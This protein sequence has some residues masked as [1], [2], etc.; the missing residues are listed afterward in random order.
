MDS[1]NMPGLARD[2]AK[3]ML[4]AKESFFRLFVHGG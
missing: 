2:T 3:N 4:D 1:A